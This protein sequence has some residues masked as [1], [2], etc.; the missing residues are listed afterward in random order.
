MAPSFKG[1]PTGMIEVDRF[2]D[3]AAAGWRRGARLR[4]S[5]GDLVDWQLFA[6]LGVT[7]LVALAGGWLGHSLSARRD[8]LNE[9]R[10]LRVTYLLEA[11]RRL[12]DASNREDPSRSWPRFESAIADIR[13]LGSPKQVHLARG[14]AREMAADHTASL[15]AMINDLRRSLREGAAAPARW[16][17]LSSISVSARAARRSSTRRSGRQCTMSRGGQGVEGAALACA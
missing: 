13:L 2:W 7:V 5:N 4:G 16:R 6:Q 8:L 11:Y 17:D 15:D 9:R 14:F 12:E 3:A 1:S 10:K